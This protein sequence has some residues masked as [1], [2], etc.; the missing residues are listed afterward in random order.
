MVLF[1]T[2]EGAASGSATMAACRIVAAPHC[3]NVDRKHR[4]KLSHQQPHKTDHNL[5]MILI[6]ELTYENEARAFDQDTLSGSH[7]RK[8]FDYLRVSEEASYTHSQRLTKSSSA[9]CEAKLDFRFTL[10][11]SG[12]KLEHSMDAKRRFQKDC[13]T[14][15]GLTKGNATLRELGERKWL[16]TVRCRYEECL[17]PSTYQCVLGLT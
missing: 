17:L 9:N 15:L 5:R 6:F 14:T 1:I 12:R 16:T 2:S 13:R 7:G 10:L 4:V 11:G 8:F 3:L